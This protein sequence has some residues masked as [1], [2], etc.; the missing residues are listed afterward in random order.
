MEEGTEEQTK[1]EELEKTSQTRRV[2]ESLHELTTM[3]IF[4]CATDGDCSRAA[5]RAGLDY[6]KMKGRTH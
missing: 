4:D 5:L 2:V 6:L 3:N 1:E